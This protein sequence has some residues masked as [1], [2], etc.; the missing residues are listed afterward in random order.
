M[1]FTKKSTAPFD[2][3]LK[4]T[5]IESWDDI[6]AHKSKG[7]IHVST[8]SAVIAEHLTHTTI[9][10]RWRNHLLITGTFFR[11]LWLII[12]DKRPMPDTQGITTSVKIRSTWLVK[13]S[14]TFQAC[15]P[16]AASIT[17]N[18]KIHLILSRTN[19]GIKKKIIQK[20]RS[21]AVTSQVERKPESYI[22]FATHT[23]KAQVWRI[24]FGNVNIVF[25]P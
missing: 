11:D 22:W 21:K 9:I 13:S 3:H 19:H 1:G 14:R 4:T 10:G 20:R 7:V 23:L 16:F 15:I 17:E 6:T 25:I 8:C 18:K 24:W 2:K 5:P 12:L